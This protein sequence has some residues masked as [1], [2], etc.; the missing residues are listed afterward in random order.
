MEGLAVIVTEVI[1]VEVVEDDGATPAASKIIAY[2]Y[3]PYV[4]IVICNI[5]TYVY[6]LYV[7]SYIW[8]CMWLLYVY[9]LYM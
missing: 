3:I 1:I 2:I 6:M 9:I 5:A 7:C 8:L 4:Q